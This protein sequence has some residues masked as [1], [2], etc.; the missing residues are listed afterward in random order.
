MQGL[1]EQESPI[2]TNPI[3]QYFSV[4]SKKER[5]DRCGEARRGLQEVG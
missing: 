1:Y 3:K 5:N 2:N 4:K